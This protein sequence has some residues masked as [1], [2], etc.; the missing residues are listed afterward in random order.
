MQIL[1]P[2]ALERA[3]VVRIAEF[4]AQLFE[5]RPVAI[6]RRLSV[7][8]S[9][10]GAEVVLDPVV[11]QKRVVDVEQEDEIVHDVHPAVG[12]GFSQGPSAPM[13]ASAAAGPQVAGS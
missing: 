6:P 12:L 11:V 1:E 4:A 13:S 10:V 3:E 2:V 7:A 8:C 9:D 5:Y